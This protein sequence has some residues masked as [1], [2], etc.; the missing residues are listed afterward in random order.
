[1]S[2]KHIRSTDEVVGI[3]CGLKIECGQCGALRK[4]DDAE[5]AMVASNSARE[6]WH[7]GCFKCDA[8]TRMCERDGA[9]ACVEAVT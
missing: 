7:R 9:V 8:S 5:I 1:M 3:Q 2:T 6:R 4:W